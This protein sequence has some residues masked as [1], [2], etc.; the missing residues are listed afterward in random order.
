MKILKWTEEEI[1]LLDIRIL[2]KTN[3]NNYF[4][5]SKKKIKNIKTQLTPNRIQK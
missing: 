4:R 2:S 5:K 1:I 3:L